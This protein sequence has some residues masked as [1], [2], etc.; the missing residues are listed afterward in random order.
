M[1]TTFA[2]NEVVPELKEHSSGIKKQ[3]TGRSEC[4]FCKSIK[5]P[6]TRS[7]SKLLQLLLL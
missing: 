7:G 5:K 2:M 4:L 3:A 6:D 1:A